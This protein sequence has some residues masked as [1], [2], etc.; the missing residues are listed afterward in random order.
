[1]KQQVGLAISIADPF[2]EMVVSKRIDT[3][4]LT[5]SLFMITC[6]LALRGFVNGAH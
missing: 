6:G 2:K 1:I 4:D 3:L 5:P